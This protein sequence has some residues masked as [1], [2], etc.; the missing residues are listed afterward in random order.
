MQLTGDFSGRTEVP[1]K[2]LATLLISQIQLAPNA[3]LLLAEFNFLVDSG[4][5]SPYFD[6]STNWG[7]LAQLAVPTP[8]G[9]FQIQRS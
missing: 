5:E 2:I 3:R 9:F 8:F 7:G 1:L 6:R 4:L